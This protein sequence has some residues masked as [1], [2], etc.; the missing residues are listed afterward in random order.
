MVYVLSF[1]LHSLLS[2]FSGLEV[3]TYEKEGVYHIPE[4]LQITIHI[5]FFR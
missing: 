2:G 1:S 3:I 4:S 5:T